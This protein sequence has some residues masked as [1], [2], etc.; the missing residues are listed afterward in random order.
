MTR[1]RD[2]SI[3]SR[4]YGLVAVSTV[5]LAAVLGLGVFFAAPLQHQGTGLPAGRP[6]QGVRHRTQSPP[7][8][9]WSL[10]HCPAANA[11]GNQ[12]RRAP[13]A[14]HPLPQTRGELPSPVRVLDAA[15]A[16]RRRQANAGSGRSC[17]GDR[18][19]PRG[20]GRIPP[21]RGQ[22]RRG[23]RGSGAG[24]VDRDHQ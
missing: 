24:S 4:L 10:V 21:P 13:P 20:P 2:Y 1:F 16:G 6:V 3:K 18:V 22:A 8:V 9:R 17:A 23:I 19:L 11:D 15:A 7:D 14:H 5:G 12:P